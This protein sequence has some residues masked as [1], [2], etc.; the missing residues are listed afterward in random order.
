MNFEVAWVLVS[1]G[2]QV[3]PQI[4][5]DPDHI[6]DYLSVSC[7]YGYPSNLFSGHVKDLNVKLYSPIRVI[8][9][10]MCMSYL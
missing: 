4:M 7:E 3:Q 9:L 10:I 6:S 5:P 2:S 1:S 8:D